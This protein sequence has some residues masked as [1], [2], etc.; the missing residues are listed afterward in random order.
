MSDLV[1]KI[2][3]KHFPKDNYINVCNSKVMWCVSLGVIA[4]F[5]NT[6][7]RVYKPHFLTRIYPTP[8]GGG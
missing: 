2:N 1:L 5:L 4:T 8:W 3:S 7:L 6:Y